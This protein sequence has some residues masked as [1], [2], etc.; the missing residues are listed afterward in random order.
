MSVATCLLSIVCTVHSHCCVYPGS[1]IFNGA[2]HSISECTRLFL[3]MGV[4]VI[5]S[6][7]VN[8]T[9]AATNNFLH[10]LDILWS[11]C[12]GVKC[13]VA[14]FSNGQIYNIVL[15]CFLNTT[16]GCI[17]VLNNQHLSNIW[18]YEISKFLKSY[19]A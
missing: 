13:W 10:V 18:H 3:L 2:K 8:T 1:L 11:M 5:T 7:F 4:F 19:W 12:W 14:V 9:R 15:N 17:R 6:F 16:N